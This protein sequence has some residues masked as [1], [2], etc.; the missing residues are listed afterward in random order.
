[1][2]FAGVAVVL[3]A[4]PGPSVAFTISR[5]LTYGRRVALLNV[6]GNS[7]GLVVQVVAVAFG[8]GTVIAR[9]AEVFS[10]LKLAG[11]AYLV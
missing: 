3:V 6:A 4:A 1:M 5:A 10:A 11:A 2:A 9:S 8:L 7:L